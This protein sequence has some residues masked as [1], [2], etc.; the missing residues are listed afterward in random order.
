MTVDVELYKKTSPV[1][2][3]TSI[4]NKAM[5][6]RQGEEGGSLAHKICYCLDLDLKT[7][8]GVWGTEE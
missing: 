6:W 7:S 8:E 5:A 4:T 1:T 2:Y 3:Q